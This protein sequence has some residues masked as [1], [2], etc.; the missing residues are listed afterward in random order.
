[1]EK[2]RNDT[3]RKNLQFRVFGGI[4]T[5]FQGIAS[6]FSNA[7]R[8][9]IEGGRDMALGDIKLSRT[10]IG[11]AAGALATASLALPGPAAAQDSQVASTPPQ[12]KEVILRVGPGFSPTAAGDIAA[13]L[14]REGC[15]VTVTQDGLFENQIEVEVG[16]DFG[17]FTESGRAGAYARKLCLGS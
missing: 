4:N 3:F 12:G 7:L 15:P 16:D 6:R 9:Y 17:E 11:A 5:I 1:M 2:L 8:I 10:W 14:N 13:I